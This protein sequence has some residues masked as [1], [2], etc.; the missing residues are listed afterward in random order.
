MAQRILLGID[1]SATVIR[2]AQASRT[3]DGYKPDHVWAERPMPAGAYRDGQI[4][5][6]HAVGQAIKD[7]LRQFK[8]RTRQVAVGVGSQTALVRRAALPRLKPERLRAMLETQGD[9]WIPFLQEGASFDLLVVNP[10]LNEREQ[11][12]L[13]VAI[14]NRLLTGL[15]AALKTAGLKLAAVEVDALALY[16]AALAKR[17]APAEG[18]VV[19]LKIDPDRFRLGLIDDGLL[20]ALRNLDAVPLA[21]PTAPIIT[22]NFLSNLRRSLEL[23]LTQ[24]KEPKPLRRLVVAADSVW[25]EELVTLVIRELQTNMPG[26]LAPEFSVSQ[27]SALETP[28]GTD[29]AF[30]LSLVQALGPVPLR[31]LARPTAAERRQQRISLGCSILL[32]VGTTTYS[33]FWHQEEPRLEQQQ[34]KLEQNLAQL[35]EALAKEPELT[36]EEARAKSLLPLLKQMDRFDPWSVAFPDLKALLPEGLMVVSLAGAP[37]ALEIVGTAVHAS[38]VSQLL[39]RLADS[40][41]FG[42]PVLKYSGAGTG[43]VSF[44]I[45]VTMSPRR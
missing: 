29:L 21:N 35:Q 14:P 33:H 32:L 6:P 39:Q 38:L 26:S 37:P 11:E 10:T 41:R 42:E 15:T 19:T 17:A 22:E 25:P 44:S 9:S 13:I 45:E 36:A 27:L 3:K 40:P 5:D 7:G 34:T 12:V 24:I 31:L 20:V 2:M 30:G 16:R 23:M 18:A 8:P 28:G 43:P 1:L 4:L